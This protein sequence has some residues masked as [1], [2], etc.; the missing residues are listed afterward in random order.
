M[1]SNALKAKKE[2]ISFPISPKALDEMTADLRKIIFH[3][4]Y[5]HY[6]GAHLHSGA[7]LRNGPGRQILDDVLQSPWQYKHP[8]QTNT[9]SKK[10]HNQSS[11]KR[12]PKQSR[13]P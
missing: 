11:Q 12:A 6:S 8:S 13:Q 4:R 5:R 9:R 7:H 10:A 2:P 1:V 3:L